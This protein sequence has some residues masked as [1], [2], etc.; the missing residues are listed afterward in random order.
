M[1]RHGKKTFNNFNTT[2]SE[3]ANARLPPSA[4]IALYKLKA[5]PR[6]SYIPQLCTPP[7]KT[8]Q[9]EKHAIETILHVPHNSLPKD[10]AYCLDQI[11]MKS[12]TPIKLMAEATCARAALKTSRIWKEQL[13]QLTNTRNEYGPIASLVSKTAH[14][15]NDSARWAT[16]AFVDNL[17]KAASIDILAVPN[18]P[19]KRFSLQAHIQK[20]IAPRHFEHN[21]ENT[22]YHRLYKFI[23]PL[24]IDEK[25]MKKLLSS[26]IKAISK[27]SPSIGLAAVKTWTNGWITDSRVG[28]SSTSPCRFGCD[29]TDPNNTDRQIHYLDCKDCGT[30]YTS[31]TSPAPTCSSNT[32]GST[33]YASS[34]HGKPNDLTPRP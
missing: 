6:L 17:N 28:A 23:S 30:T 8:A 12:F 33:H 24:A 1:T 10:T 3:I 31:P 27:L 13:T 15:H 25:K 29:P 18:N 32:R 2:V 5:F 22:L 19:L 11:G 9:I 7:A 21:L 14:G 26:S 34:P 20:H 4:G 16:C